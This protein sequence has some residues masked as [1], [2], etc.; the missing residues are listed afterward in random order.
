M[1]NNKNKVLGG[2]FWDKKQVDDRGILEVMWK[3]AFGDKKIRIVI[4][5]H[6]PLIHPSIK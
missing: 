5:K 6:K 4:P 3:S 2:D 1:S